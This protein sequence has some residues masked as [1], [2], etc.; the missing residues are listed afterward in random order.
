[1]GLERFN[2]SFKRF[3]Q[4]LGWYPV[5]LGCA[6]VTADSKRVLPPVCLGLKR[7]YPPH[8]PAARDSKRVLPPVRKANANPLIVS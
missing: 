4:L 5:G 7:L 2:M 6:P 8:E 3:Y 1:M